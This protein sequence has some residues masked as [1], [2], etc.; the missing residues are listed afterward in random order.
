M[1]FLTLP[2]CFFVLL[3]R[4][5]YFLITKSWWFLQTDSVQLVVFL[6]FADN[7]RRP[8]Q[9]C[10]LDPCT[11]CAQ[12]PTFEQGAARCGGSARALR[13]PAL[14][15]SGQTAICLAAHRRHH[16]AL[17]SWLSFPGTTWR[18]ALLQNAEPAEISNQNGKADRAREVLQSWDDR[19]PRVNWSI[20][21]VWFSCGRNIRVWQPIDQ[22]KGAVGF[23][24]HARQSSIGHQTMYDAKFFYRVFFMNFAE[25]QIH[26][27][28][29]CL[30]TCSDRVTT[31]LQRLTILCQISFTK[32]FRGKFLADFLCRSCEFTM[33]P[34]RT[35]WFA[36]SCNYCIIVPLYE[37]ARRRVCVCTCACASVRTKKTIQDNAQ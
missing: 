23:T 34:L 18:D 35:A 30:S 22:M 19:T 1:L 4:L 26:C 29:L 32:K 31:V 21:G 27:T 12:G 36:D 20:L 33:I 24:L 25:A 8:W 5:S 3:T 37:I 14:E 6:W 11:V 2:V 9:G 16:P 17:C 13:L 15:T 7:G 28:L 10:G